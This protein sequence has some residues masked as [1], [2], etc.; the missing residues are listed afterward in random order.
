MGEAVVAVLMIPPI[1]SLNKSRL[2]GK[3]R[4]EGVES[5]LAIVENEKPEYRFLLQTASVQ[6]SED[7]S[8]QSTSSADNR[9][10]QNSL[11]MM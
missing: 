2:V 3:V 8:A 6:S 1:S 4:R 10:E 11:S 7:M 9:S 5:T